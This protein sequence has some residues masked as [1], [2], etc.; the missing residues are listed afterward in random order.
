MLL[1][2]KVNDVEKEL[3]KFEDDEKKW[4]TKEEELAKKE[5]VNLIHSF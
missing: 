1:L 2:Q 4:R 3:K 5:K